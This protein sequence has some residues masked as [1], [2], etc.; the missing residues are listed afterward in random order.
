MKRGAWLLAATVGA[1]V[2]AAG[3]I[4]ATPGL[5]WRAQLVTLKLAGRTPAL[6]WA[7]L[8]EV[9]RGRNG[10]WTDR[11][12]ESQN[13]FVAL[14]APALVDADITAGREL[15]VSACAGCH[16]SEGAGTPAGPSLT[17]GGL[18]H[19]ASDLALFLA[20]RRGFPGTAMQPSSLEARAV[21][22]V[23][24]FLKSAM[25][26]AN[27]P[28]APAALTE[29]VAAVDLAPLPAA[30]CEEISDW[31]SFH[32][33]PDGRRHSA[34]AQINRI[35]V[36]RLQPGWSFAFP[37]RDE[38]ALE[39]TPIVAGGR[40]F[41]STPGGD[42]WALHASTG[43]L[44]WHRAGHPLP[45]DLVKTVEGN[46]NR[47]VAVL[48]D[49]VVVPEI[50]GRLAGL[51]AQTG[52][53][54]WSTEVANYRA[55]YRLIGAPLPV[56]DAV[57]VGVGGA[58]RG[59]RGFLDAY[60][61]GTGQ[62]LW[63]LYT[64]E[65]ARGG[66]TTAVTGTYDPAL[67]LVFWGTGNPGPGFDGDA[68]PGDNRHASS[69]IAVDATNGSL[70]WSYQVA[71]HDERDWGVTHVPMLVESDASR[72]TV[73]RVASRNGFVYTLD[74]ATGRFLQATPYAHQIWN[75]GFDVGG[76]PIEREHTRPGARGTLLYP[77][78]AGA[79]NWEPPSFDAAR[80]LMYVMSRDGYGNIL[81]K[82]PRESWEDGAFW[83]GQ[84][85]GIRQVSAQVRAVSAAT[86][87]V[88]WSYRFPGPVNYASSGTLSTAG[89]VVF[90]GEKHRF[91]AL[92]AASGREL[93]HHES[94]G[95]IAAAP[96]TWA[97]ASG[98]HVA[99]VAG[100]ALLTFSLP[101]GACH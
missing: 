1:V 13:P 98:Q 6:S 54:R 62:R 32:G 38:T 78:H 84:A 65:S 10:L 45:D 57:I 19:G 93:W 42:T 58:D 46:V 2:L 81:F 52:R 69:V 21:W 63:R 51:D 24:G 77:G 5:R 99:V 88:R 9:I 64:V 95:P 31:P 15:F 47:G 55:G 74:R 79:T 33:E 94:V 18:R 72:S 86:G 91:V 20:I 100:G 22:Q 17:S 80:G 82:N 39:A 11:L 97:D 60:S 30:S 49:T 16:G 40:L 67:D 37:K 35:N 14:T 59:V 29:S 76:R 44:L 85:L 28:A 4:L 101:P 68:R 26:D 3:V 41:V 56:R 23:V 48:G 87:E 75:E 73:V 89:G 25:F 34:L 66:G 50:D 36:S 70:R 53:Q 43:Q 83:G 27:T 8:R 92:D 96:M 12:L 61:A 7:E 71:P 90:A